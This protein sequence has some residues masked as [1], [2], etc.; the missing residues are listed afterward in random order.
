MYALPCRCLLKLFSVHMC[1]QSNLKRNEQIFIAFYFEEEIYSNLLTHRNG[2]K[3]GTHYMTIC[4]YFFVYISHN[5]LNI[6]CSKNVLNEVVEKNGR[7][8]VTHFFHKC[9]IGINIIHLQWSLCVHFITFTAN[10][11]QGSFEHRQRLLNFLFYIIIKKALCR[12]HFWST[13]I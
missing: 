2:Q 1:A 8:F 6:Y 12:I 4:M 7:H 9:Y 10:N 13:S 3:W 5:F 11:Q